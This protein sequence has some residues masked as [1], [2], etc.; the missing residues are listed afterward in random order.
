M[1]TSRRVAPHRPAVSARAALGLVLY[2][3]AAGSIIAFDLEALVTPT[4]TIPPW[5]ALIVPPAAYA[6]LAAIWL[7]R[8]PRAQV[9]VTTSILVG[10]H[11]AL[12][13]LAAWVETLVAGVK[14]T[15]AVTHVAWGMPLLT[16]LQVVLVP[17]TLIPVCRVLLPAPRPTRTTRPAARAATYP[18]EVASGPRRA[19][20]VEL[21]VEPTAS[22]AMSSQDL[23]QVT[24]TP[25]A[26]SRDAMMSAGEALTVP[27]GDDGSGAAPRPHSAE[28]VEEV[29]RVGFER[30]ATQL[31][32]AAFLLPL[33]RVAANLLE[34]DH[35]LVPRR[36]VAPQLPEGVVRVA[37][38]VVADQFPRQGLAMP[39]AEIA[40]RLPNGCLVLPLDEIVRQ[41]PMELFA[42]SS[43]AADVRGIDDFPMPFQPHVLTVDD[44]VPEA[45]E[46]PA[47]EDSEPSPSLSPG[48]SGGS[49]APGADLVAH[50]ELTGAPKPTPAPNIAASET[51]RDPAVY[52]AGPAGQD[53]VGVGTSERSTAESCAIEPVSLTTPER[54]TAPPPVERAPSRDATPR[55]RSR[56]FDLAEV[57]A[58][59]TPLLGPLEIDERY[60][61]GLTLVAAVAPGVDGDAAIATAGPFLPFV[62]DPRL[63]WAISQATVRATGG[64]LVVT[65]V[66]PLE[67]GATVLV[68]AV[69]PGA[70]LAMVERAS[71]RVVGDDDH[72]DTPEPTPRGAERLADSDLRAAAVPPNVRAVAESLRAFGRVT[73]AVLRDSAGTLLMYLF[74]PPDVD[75][76]S[77]AGFARDL[78]R[79]FDGAALGAVSSVIARVGA[80][81]LVV[82]ELDAGR[83]CT[84]VL[85]AFG[86]VDR[87][88]LARIELERAA[89]RLAAL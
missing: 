30:I 78:R 38:D 86:P 3:L 31:P 88:G 42:L 89:L 4:L 70:P 83:S 56:R 75:P 50:V 59:L 65:P 37:W 34:P 73:P 84:S 20:A 39:D 7:A 2:G 27:N 49:R 6:A 64:S 45:R 26:S 14:F 1:T 35:L 22:S 43:P 79:H 16:A 10:G 52:A 60:H 28:R 63:P 15:V 11:W 21:P 71:L 57:S 33:D 55:A 25:T 67:R 77:M 36:L 13:A 81:R 58:Q 23:G 66:G 5:A 8:R 29:I 40:R 44:D 62:S 41:L 24:P 72:V 32:A 74:L 9:A 47:A 61:A 48:A 82:W 54:F 87:P 19:P 76:R 17:W 51:H 53:T 69:V 85:V 12:V 68:A 18:R 46:E 80:H